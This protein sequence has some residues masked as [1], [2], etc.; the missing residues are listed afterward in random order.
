MAYKKM[1]RNVRPQLKSIFIAT[2]LLLGLMNIPFTAHAQVS[3]GDVIGDEPG[4]K[5]VVLNDHIQGCTEAT[6]G[7]TIIGPATLDMNGYALVCNAD[8]PPPGITL[9]GQGAQFVMARC[10]SASSASSSAKGAA[11]R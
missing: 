9:D 4:E 5:K 2:S 1:T 6:G 7:I 8:G 3:C 10:S 11:Y